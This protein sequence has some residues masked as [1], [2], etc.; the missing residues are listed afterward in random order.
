MKASLDGDVLNAASVKVEAIGNNNADAK[1]LA[2]AVGLASGAGADAYAEVTSLATVEALVGSTAQLTVP[3]GPVDV[4]ATGD[5]NAVAKA[6]GG[7]VAGLAIAAMLPTAKVGGSVKAS[8]DGGLTGGSLNVKA[9]AEN[10]ATA[11]TVVFSVSLL[12]GSGARA[13]AEVTSSAGTDAQVD[14]NASITV[15]GSSSSMRACKA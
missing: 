13:T 11:T 9:L 3:N 2:I 15:T 8:F 6:D 4:L 1:A 14:S 12:G 5:N 10:T 7:G